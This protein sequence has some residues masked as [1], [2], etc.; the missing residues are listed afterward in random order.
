MLGDFAPLRSRFAARLRAGCQAWQGF[1]AIRAAAGR[2]LQ[3][4]S[5]RLGAAGQALHSLAE[6]LWDGLLSTIR[7]TRLAG[8]RLGRRWALLGLPPL[9]AAAGLG[10]WLT[11]S[12][13]APNL[14]PLADLES[15]LPAH[16]LAVLQPV[17]TETVEAQMATLSMAR[18]VVIR[19][20]DTLM[21]L[22]ID[23]GIERP[24][25]ANAIEAMR[26]VFRPRDLRPGQAMHLA[27][28]PEQDMSGRGGE[29][30]LRLVSLTLQSRPDQDIRVVRAEGDGGF[31]A[32]AI[33]RPL[34][35]EVTGSAGIIE[36]SLFTAG[37]HS[38]VPAPVMIEVI[39]AFSFDVDFQREVRKADDFELLFE[40]HYDEDGAL[41]KLGSVLY[42]ALTLSGRRLELYRFTPESGVTDYFDSK[43]RSVR[44]A[45]LRTP[46]DGARLS[47]GYGP[48]KHPILGYT[49]MHRGLDFAAPRGTPIYAAGDGIVERVGRYGSYGKYLRIRHN[50]TYKTAYAH[51]N[52]FAKSLKKGARVKQGQIVGYVGSTGRST[53]PHLHYEVIANGRQ[54]NPRK[55]KLPSG[56][57]LKGADLKDFQAFRAR[58]QGL[59]RER[60]AQPQLVKA[61][62]QAEPIERPSA[63]DSEEPQLQSC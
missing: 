42:A 52:R 32:E 48:R 55:I 22:L 10:F 34:T 62:C 1:A 23:A 3:G 49:K 37:L 12:G 40:S 44:K 56:E 19:R 35:L 8:H 29:P 18:K 15:D 2:A 17:P 38:G 26:E 25:A 13:V 60:P 59:R 14:L 50:G 39:R 51:L 61:T 46:V 43:G 58:I 6:L 21:K 16:H 33:E 54:I 4:R 47:S 45:L 9:L 63:L 5:A 57:Q 24:E 31:V 7:P 53:G 41:A 27:F 28:A 20:G 36:S 11:A 30:P